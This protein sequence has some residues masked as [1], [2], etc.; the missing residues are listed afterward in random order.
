MNFLIL[1]FKSAFGCCCLPG[2]GLGLG[3]GFAGFA[4]GFGG[5]QLDK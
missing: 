1:D 4:A 3:L 5:E 2:G